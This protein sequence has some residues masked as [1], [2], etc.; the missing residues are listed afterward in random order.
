MWVNATI[1]SPSVSSTVTL[2][3]IWGHPLCI[4]V[5][6]TRTSRMHEISLCAVSF[7]AMGRSE[8]RGQPGPPL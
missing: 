1:H 8:V 2:A 5:E 6:L 3:L 4:A 7:M